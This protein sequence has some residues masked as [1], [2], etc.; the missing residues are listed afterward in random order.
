MV[1]ASSTSKPAPS[2]GGHDL[3]SHEDSADRTPSYLHCNNK[4]DD[5]GITLNYDYDLSIPLPS[6]QNTYQY[7]QNI[8]SW[9]C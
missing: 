7:Y 9:R 2:P 8:S 4:G 6:Q 5:P 3:G 1:T